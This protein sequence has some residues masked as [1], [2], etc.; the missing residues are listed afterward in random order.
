M[1]AHKVGGEVDAFCTRCKMTLAHT[2]LAMVG[3]KVARVRCN[4]C[5]S[6]HS[7]RGAPG[8][9]P[10]KAPS[11]ARSSAASKEKKVVISFA[12]RLAGKDASSARKY[13]AKE[14]F[15]VDDLVDH[16]TFG[17]GF[18]VAVRQ[19]KVDIAFKA[20]QKTLVHGRGGGP[21]A[22]RPSF[23]PPSAP[24]QAP[25]DKPSPDDGGAAVTDAPAA[26]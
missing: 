8:S 5:N 18:V 4:T 2:I 13:S 12:E 3:T 7:F 11:R 22:E 16:P 10:T 19:D 25:A 26:E 15:A 21:V 23:H 9:S 17:L 14:T 20:D 6:D 24:V 1:A